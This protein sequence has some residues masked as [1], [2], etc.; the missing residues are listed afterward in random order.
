[1]AAS[2]PFYLT[3]E[4]SSSLSPQ[5][6]ITGVEENLEFA[7]FLDLDGLSST[8]L[9]CIGVFTI[10]SH[11]SPGSPLFPVPVPSQ[12]AEEKVPR[13]KSLAIFIYSSINVRLFLLLTQF[14][15]GRIGAQL[16]NFSIPFEPVF[17]FLQQNFII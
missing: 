11:Q 16:M 7:I 12:A 5:K 8:W 2:Y 17:T 10:R 3:E 13:E 15:Y 1:L 4:E 9:P 14:L 6:R